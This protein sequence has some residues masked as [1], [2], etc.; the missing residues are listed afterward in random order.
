METYIQVD[1]IAK[2]YGDIV[3]FDDIA[4]SVMKD[5]K[6]ALIA[7]NGAGKSTILKIIAGEETPD[8]G[9][10]IFRNDITLGYLSQEPALNPDQ[11]ILEATFL[12]DSQL[13]QAVKN[14]ELAMASGDSHQIQKAMQKMEQLQAWDFEVEAK[15]ILTQ[16]NI[17]EYD[18][19]IAKLSGGERKR[20]ALAHVLL[21]KP[22]ILILD[23]PT[24]HLDLEMIEWLEGFL[25]KSGATLLMVT[26]DRYFLD[27]VCTNILE[28]DDNVVYRYDGNY[29]YYLEKR[30]ERI[31]VFNANT[32]KARNLLKKEEEWVK[33][34][35]KAR[36]TKAKFRIDNYQ[37]IKER[38]SQEKKEEEVNLNFK[39]KRLGKKVINA[40]NLQKSFDDQFLINNFSYK[41]APGEK[42]GIVGDNGSGKSTLLHLL[43]GE[44]KPDQGSIEIGETVRIGYYK[45]RGIVFDDNKR[46]IEVIQEIAEHITLGNGKQMPAAQFLEYF[47][48]PKKMHYNYVHKLSGGE[49]RR[50]YLMTVLMHSPNFLILDEPTNDLDILTLN[51]LEDYLANFTGCVII[52][53]HD[54]YF[55]DKVVDK[56]FVFQN[57]GNIQEFP[58]N[59]TIYREKQKED[60]TP[61]KPAEK[62]AGKKRDKPKETKYFRYK[63]KMELEALEQEMED[64]QQEKRELEDQL[65]SGEFIGEKLNEKSLRLKHIMDS[66]DEKEMRWLELQE[67]KELDENK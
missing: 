36:G 5:Q 19:I 44:L 16:L 13:V 25:R 45:Q 62:K 49:K 41:F 40:Y 61:I 63:H 23:E 11:N 65:N 15:Q 53:S 33:R 12:S 54:R 37:K 14:Y 52:V 47:L 60:K 21:K 35:P 2:A 31:E 46:L 51:V 43:T 9:E 22:D 42:I 28:L 38:A 27:R 59:Y 26:H 8:K 50:L 30:S 24:N 3:L 1:T 57:Q 48:F 4:F 32:E 18:K 34:M 20:V 56:L 17:N 64:M 67:L 6:T 39:S 58:G 10:I 29:S 55:M 66:L 7:R